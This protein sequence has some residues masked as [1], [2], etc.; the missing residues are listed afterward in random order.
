MNDSLKREKMDENLSVVLNELINLY[1]F[2]TCESVDL[3]ECQV[4]RS[5]LV[6]LNTFAKITIDRKLPSRFIDEDLLKFVFMF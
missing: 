6:I 2:N 3:L 5:S 4:K 1:Y